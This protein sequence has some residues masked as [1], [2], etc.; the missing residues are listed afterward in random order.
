MYLQ[1]YEAKSHLN[2]NQDYHEDDE[3][4]VNLIMVAENILQKH[5]DIEL[6][7]LEDGE[8]NLPQPILHAMLVLVASFYATRESVTYASA[9][10]MPHSY[11]Y[12]IALYKNYAGPK[13]G[14]S[15]ISH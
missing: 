11:E 15:N 4:I 8:G 7:E 12:L 1:L 9:R 6:K 13:E 3:Y 14:T 5:L 10:P 2:V